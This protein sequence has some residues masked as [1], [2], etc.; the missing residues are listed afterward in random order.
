[1]EFLL[2]A[3]SYSEISTKLFI[4]HSTVKMHLENASI[5]RHMSYV[6]NKTPFKFSSGYTWLV[7]VTY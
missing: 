2:A 1:M 5:E 6:S 3:D 4:S 7:P